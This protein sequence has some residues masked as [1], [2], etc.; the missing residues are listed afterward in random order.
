MLIDGV[1]DHKGYALLSVSRG[2]HHEHQK[3]KNET[4][5]NTPHRRYSQLLAA[6]YLRRRSFEEL[7]YAAFAWGVVGRDEIIILGGHLAGRGSNPGFC[8]SR[9]VRATE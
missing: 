7:G 4:E 1:A 3:D 9:T 5:L 2:H 8:R 6:S